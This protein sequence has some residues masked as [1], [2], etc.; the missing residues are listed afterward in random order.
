M[1]RQNRKH[2]AASNTFHHQLEEVYQQHRSVI[3]RVCRCMVRVDRA[4]WDNIKGYLGSIH[5]HFKVAVP[6][7]L[8]MSAG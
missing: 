6:A 5:E 8:A 4:M 7:T 2:H 1:D 3:E